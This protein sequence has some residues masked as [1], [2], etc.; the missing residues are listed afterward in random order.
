MLYTINCTKCNTSKQQF[1]NTFF[2]I[3]QEDRLCKEVVLTGARN[4]FEQFIVVE[5]RCNKKL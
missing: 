2:I 4:N 5:K 1:C 3:E